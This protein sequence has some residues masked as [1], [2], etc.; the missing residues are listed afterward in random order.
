MKKSKTDAEQLTS[1]SN[2]NNETLENLQYSPEIEGNKQ[3]HPPETTFPFPKRKFGSKLQ[4]S[5][6]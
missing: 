1:K 2:V 5:L 6:A 3:F 4:C